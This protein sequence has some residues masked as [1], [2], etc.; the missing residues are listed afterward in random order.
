[1]PLN[2]IAVFLRFLFAAYTLDKKTAKAANKQ[3][4]NHKEAKKENFNEAVRTH[5]HVDES[6]MNKDKSKS[7]GEA[8][9][10]T[11]RFWLSDFYC[12]GKEVLDENGYIPEEFFKL[13]NRPKTK[14]SVLSTQ[15]HRAY[16][17]GILND[18]NEKAKP[19]E[20]RTR[21]A[22]VKFFDEHIYSKLPLKTAEGWELDGETA[23]KIAYE[24]PDIPGN[25]DINQPPQK[26]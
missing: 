16:R 26:T 2:R 17:M 14:R 12:F 4:K 3:R 20:K 11:K 10:L 15:D 6:E 5:P 21:Y 9:V 8:K 19:S 13:I 22:T 18:L 7:T 24:L 1:M 25:V 23:Y